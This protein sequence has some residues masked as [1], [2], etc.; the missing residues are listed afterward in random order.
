P[1]VKVERSL[2]EQME[3][4][5]A[6]DQLRGPDGKFA[7]NAGEN[8][9]TT[10]EHLKAQS[11]HIGKARDALKAGNHEA[12]TEHQKAAHEHS[13]AAMASGDDKAVASLTAQQASKVANEKTGYVARSLRYSDDQPR[14]LD[15]KFAGGGESKGFVEHNP[16][17]EGQ[18]PGADTTNQMTKKE[19]EGLTKEEKLGPKAGDKVES[20]FGTKGT[21]V[22]PAGDKTKVDV[23]GRTELWPAAHF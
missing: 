9:K 1:R 6:E 3:E 4:R 10:E 18:F 20:I 8:A 21:V 22:G 14:D 17:G 2:S 15:G 12:A 16:E 13:K 19:D 7:S 11:E 23:G 5:F